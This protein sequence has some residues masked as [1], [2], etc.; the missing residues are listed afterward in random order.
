MS[1]THPY[2]PMPD[3][4]I[5]YIVREITGT[6]H[7]ENGYLD[8]LT[9]NPIDNQR[10]SWSTVNTNFGNLT[11]SYRHPQEV[12][13]LPV[14]WNSTLKDGMC[15]LPDGRHYFGEFGNWQDVYVTPA[16][17]KITLNPVAGETVDQV[18]S[19]FQGDASQ[20]I[21]YQTHWIYRTLAFVPKWGPIIPPAGKKMVRTSLHEV[22]GQ[23]VYNYIYL[24]GVG[25]VAVWYGQL[26]VDGVSV[27]G[28]E[29]RMV[30]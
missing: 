18:S 15:V 29:K 24:E 9:R 4:G 7:P 14:V 10:I 3:G 27:V 8:V 23:M 5:D 11:A 30:V 25:M 28:F 2:V 1:T 26:A 17:C 16:E 6:W 21:L 20:T 13:D 19:V 12:P 22:D